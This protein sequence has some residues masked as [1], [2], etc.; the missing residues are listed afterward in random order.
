M[1]YVPRMSGT[2]A[3][4]T[5]V[6]TPEFLSAT[7]KLLTE[8]ERAVLVDYLA[9]NPAASELV[10]GTGGV[11]KLRWRLEGRGKRGGAR[12]IYFYHSAQ[13]PLFSLTAYAKNERAI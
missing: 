12:V 8:E 5:V 10:P 4:I 7:R 2:V 3:P 6:E 9:H 13:V 11:R 1:D